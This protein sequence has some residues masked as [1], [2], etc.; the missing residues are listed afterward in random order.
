MLAAAILGPAGCGGQPAVTTPTVPATAP[1]AQASVDSTDSMGSAASS[2]AAPPSAS[3]QPTATPPAGSGGT[4]A[5]APE[6]ALVPVAGF[7]TE[8]TDVTSAQVAAILA[9]TDKAF[10]TLELLQGDSAAILEAV[11]QR[12]AIASAH[13]VAAA[14]VTALDADVA[15]HADRLG[16][17]RASQ[18]EA[19]VRALSWEG[20][21]LFG[22][23]RVKNLAEW[24]LKARAAGLATASDG[25]VASEAFD[26][27]QLW[28][29]AAGG[30]VML[31][32]GVSRTIRAQSAG[33]D[34]PFEGGSAS[35]AGHRCCTSFGWPIPIAQRTSTEPLVRLML[36]NADVAMVNLEGPAPD[37][38][39]YHATGMTFNFNQAYLAGLEDAGIDI[40]SL[41]NNH[42]GNAGASGVGQTVTALDRIGIAHTGAAASAAQ[43]ATPALVTI[44]GVRVA[45]I[46][47]S[48]FGYS[49]AASVAAAPGE[50][51]AARAAGAQVVIVY[52]HWGTEY[53]ATA[54]SYERNWAHKMIDAGADLVIGNHAH[55]AAAMEVYKGKPIWYALG[56][57][58]FDQSWSEPT[59]EGLLLELTFNG[60]RLVQ[61]WMHP[62]LI[63]D[64]AQ[65][66]FLD[67]VSG[68]VV[69]DQ[70]YKA[71]GKLLPW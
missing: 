38:A 42:I 11:G 44:D 37:H 48:A 25:S 3:A 56:N 12:Q 64:E 68:R 34:F 7:R 69:L 58:V 27:A 31:D 36:S 10:T 24:P 20:K 70:V 66:N 61:A 45:V 43:A 51:K 65:P 41:A 22:V 32:R 49:L 53:K 54:N 28:T 4:G 16:I 17:V 46:G 8:Q 63:L 21:S 57:F 33:Y 62:L 52:P 9:G 2:P 26:P 39:R 67:T 71:S 50:I 23:A 6:V 18:V 14:S 29:A 35:I 59:Q 19:G 30:D 60:T 55:W 15:G 47:V 1:S 5:A 40:V 13:L